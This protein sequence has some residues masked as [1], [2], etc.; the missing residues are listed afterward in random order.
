MKIKLV[1]S[2]T[3]AD[4]RARRGRTRKYSNNLKLQQI[5]VV[6]VDFDLP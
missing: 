6:R 5:K 2:W 3:L 1:T 4:V